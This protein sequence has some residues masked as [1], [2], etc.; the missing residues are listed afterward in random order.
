MFRR[1]LLIASAGFIAL[2]TMAGIASADAGQVASPIREGSDGTPVGG[3][4]FD[5]SMNSDGQEILTIR[6]S[7]PGGMS[8]DFVCLSHDAFTER[9]A[10]GQCDYSHDPLNGATSDEFSVNL[11]TDYVN[12]PVY[13]QLH[14]GVVMPAGTAFAGWQDGQPFYGNVQ[15]DPTPIEGVPAAPLLGNWMP[16]GLG[17]LFVLG[18]GAIGV[19]YRRRVTSAAS[20]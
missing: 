12:E 14:V 4:N 15:V 9:V 20:D 10:A 18:T 5:R 17:A 1:L 11:G 3:A 6:L 19:R 13:V 8:A 16:L 2:T 7:V